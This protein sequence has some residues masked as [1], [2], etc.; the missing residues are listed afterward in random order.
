M[1][2]VV[3]RVGGADSKRRSKKLEISSFKNYWVLKRAFYTQKSTIKI[4]CKIL[5]N[6]NAPKMY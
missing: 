3:Y 1:I 6:F 5:Q 2:T 4:I